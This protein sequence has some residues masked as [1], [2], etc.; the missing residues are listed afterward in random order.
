M[1]N[2]K[3]NYLCSLQLILFKDFD[4]EQLCIVF[5]KSANEHACRIVSRVT[6]LC[7]N[8]QLHRLLPSSIICGT[9]N[10]CWHLQPPPLW[11]GAIFDVTFCLTSCLFMF[12]SDEY[13]SFFNIFC[14]IFLFFCIIDSWYWPFL[15]VDGDVFGDR[16][17]DVWAE[18]ALDFLNVFFNSYSVAIASKTW[19]K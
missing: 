19:G 9:V 11:R 5:C 12:G 3:K 2:L 18:V 14:V 16:A 7:L 8:W 15:W 4:K 10:S 1:R 13:F 17:G 6:S